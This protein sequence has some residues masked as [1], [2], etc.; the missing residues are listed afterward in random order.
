LPGP[1]DLVLDF[2]LLF[3]G[4]FDGGDDASL[5]PCDLHHLIPFLL[6]DYHLAT[7]FLALVFLLLVLGARET[8]FVFWLLTNL[9]LLWLLGYGFCELYL[10]FV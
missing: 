9:W 8:S 2:F 7:T 10:F 3:G 6:L 1:P 5:P 4:L